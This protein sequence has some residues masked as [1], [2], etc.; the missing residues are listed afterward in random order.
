MNLEAGGLGFG[1][2]INGGVKEDG[3][4]WRRRSVE[5]RFRM[6]GF[7]VVC[8]GV[9]GRGHVV[10][11]RRMMRK[12]GQVVVKAVLSKETMVKSPAVTTEKSKYL[13]PMRDFNTEVFFDHSRDEERTVMVVF[14][15]DRHGMLLD[16]MSVLTGLGLKV[17]RV[18]DSEADA[19]NMMLPRVEGELM[20][21]SELGLSTENTV[22][23]YITE[24]DGE[25]VYSGD[26][27]ALIETMVKRELSDR[28]PRPQVDNSHWHRI[29]VHRNRGRNM[30]AISVST[31]H[32]QDVR[33]HVVNRLEDM[34][35]DVVSSTVNLG[36]N[37]AE[38]TFFVRRAGKSLDDDALFKISSDLVHAAVGRFCSESQRVW[39]QARVF[40]SIAVAEAIVLDGS[41][42]KSDP[43]L[44]SW[45][46]Y[47]TPNFRGRLPDL[48]YTRL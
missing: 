29:W 1:G 28:Y 20:S 7:G 42:L 17:H 13:F 40:P 14:C 19:L 44:V 11:G 4:Y 27:M 39:Y 37:R 26:R 3:C 31:I 12:S 47:E 32:G 5:Y 21:L 33:E 36:N 23:Y 22:A 2:F 35:I 38:N 24:D 34:G 15:R 25:K 16:V 46:K 9:L 10:E 48:P 18:C 30:S 41:I 43:R 6:L 45:E 8:G